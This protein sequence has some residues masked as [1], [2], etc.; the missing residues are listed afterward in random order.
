MQQIQDFLFNNAEAKNADFLARLVPT[1]DR[2]KILG[3]RT[4]I[5][6]KYARQLWRDEPDAAHRFLRQLPHAT[7]DENCLHAF[8]I[9]QEKDF[10]FTMKLTEEFLPFIDNWATCDSFKPPVFK[11]YSNEV[12]QK[13]LVWLKSEHVYTVRYSIG[14]LLSNFL[15]KEFKAEILDLV[16][17]VESDEYYVHMM[18]AWFFAEALFKQSKATLSFLENGMIKNKFVHNKAIQKAIESRR[19]SDELKDYLRQLRRK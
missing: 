11:K 12:Y 10:W 6:R 4:P 19:I 2:A 17:N 15:D 18:Q 7:F 13:I 9:E 1:V 5:L 16:N 8:V 3:I 14:L